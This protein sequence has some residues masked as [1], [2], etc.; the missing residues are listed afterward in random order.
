MDRVQKLEYEKSMEDYFHDNKIY[1]LMESLFEELIINKPE[2]PIDYLIN[3]LK[4]KKTTKIFITGYAGSNAKNISL[5]LANSLGFSCLKIS[6]LLEREI[7][8][9]NEKS[10]K[11]KKNFE[12]CRLVDDETV[13]DLLREK[14][15]KF[16]EE[17]VSYIIE[18][19]PR[20]R[21]Q[22]I[23]LQSSGLLPDNII[24]LTTSE[25]NSKDAVYEKIKDNFD[26]NGIE[27][28]TKE[29]GSMAEISVNESVINLKSLKEIF[30]GFFYEIN[31]DDFEQESDVI[32]SLA[33]LLK[34]KQKTNEARKPPHIM[35]I[36][37]PCLNK[38]K[39]GKLISSQL[40]IIHV[41]IMDL[42][43]KEISSKNENS[44][45]ILASLEQNDLVHNKHILKLLE[46][47]LY[48]SECMINGWIITG[49]P[50]S[51]L[52]IN[53]MEKMNSEIKPSLYALIDA[54]EKKIEENAS[55]K[56]Y[57]PKSGKSYV[58][59][60]KEYSEL[61][62]EDI[63]RLEKRKQDEGEILKKRIENWKKIVKILNERGYKNLINIDGNKSES[64]IA[65]TI[66]DAV[67]FNS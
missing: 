42:L 13:I 60:S 19:F 17:N 63:K 14:I 37:P 39:I 56:R 5:S 32:E 23:F 47:R 9:N 66:I 50:K 65:E 6:D 52:Q 7:S 15:I 29:I 22:A 62:E 4:R 16:E 38:N 18:G 51:E 3:R 55:K 45:N 30:G 24:M 8:K 43:R 67:G 35:L 33:T 59:G 10:E 46:D 11:I 2:N 21:T 27:K 28:D 40:R 48:S 25:R 57:D 44:K 31:V 58:E 12:E 1:D 26:N 53:Y 36:A 64:K 49:F 34:F 20:N 61:R 41:D 54:D